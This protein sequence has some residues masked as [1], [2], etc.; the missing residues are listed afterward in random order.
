MNGSRW[1]YDMPW[2]DR[3]LPDG[4]GSSQHKSHWAAVPLK[5]DTLNSSLTRGRNVLTSG[6]PARA[7]IID[8]EMSLGLERLSLE[9]HTS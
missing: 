7:V 8:P 4:V 9:R 5:P 2:V 6:K 3:I 1:C